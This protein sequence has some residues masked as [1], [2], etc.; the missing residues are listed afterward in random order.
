[1][2]ILNVSGVSKCYGKGKASVQALKN[3]SF[4]VEKGKF[5]GIMGASGSG[6]STLLNLISTIDYATE[7]NI[8]INDTNITKLN[9]KK[10]DKFRREKLGFIFQDFR[11]LDSLMISEN[12]GMPLVI[13]KRK[14]DEIEKK[15][16]EIMRIL[17]IGRLA[18]KYPYQISGGEKQRTA[19]ARAII[20]EPELI[21]ADEPTGLWTPI[22]HEIL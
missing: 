13:Q 15:V 11:L 17:D 8:I 10:A 12:I 7:G 21:L 9:I 19:C 1:M 5:I 6:K 20:S 22:M 4:T 18:E 3:I 16:N 14:R 2:D